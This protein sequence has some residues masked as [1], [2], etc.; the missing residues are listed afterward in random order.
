[1]PN[2][3]HVIELLPAYALG[4]L[5][6]EETVQVSEHLAT[7][8]EC[9]AELLAYEAVAEQLALA[10]PE[11]APPA[12]LKQRIMDC[13]QTPQRDEL[14]AYLAEHRIGCAIFYPRPLHLQP[15]FADLGYQVGD[16]PV[17]ERLADNVLSLPIYAELTDAQVD[18][19]ARTII[20]FYESHDR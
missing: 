20:D 6:E 18:H 9:R 16:F 19:V 7:C 17:A 4:S 11:V 13:I 10:A 15:C 5:N 1:M 14:Q 12:E 2:D 3:V 8:P